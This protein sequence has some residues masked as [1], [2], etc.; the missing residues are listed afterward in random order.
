MDFEKELMASTNLAK[1]ILRRMLRYSCPEDVE[2]VLQ[3]AYLKAWLNRCTFEGRSKFSTWFTKIVMNQALMKLRTLK[4]T[5]SL[6]DVGELIALSSL[7]QERLV[8]N[9]EMLDK[10]LRLL[11]SRA[12]KV[13]MLRYEYG[14]TAK[15]TSTVMD[16][17]LENVKSF[18]H[19]GRRK[20]QRNLAVRKGR[21]RWR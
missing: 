2:D 11:S 1:N 5:D 21:R 16:M 9:R 7:S 3:E 13:L 18:C 20:I 6:E 12:R 17:G 8:S 14:Y 19:R 15:E 10:G 4:K